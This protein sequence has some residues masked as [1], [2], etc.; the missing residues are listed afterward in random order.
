MFNIL[1][2]KDLNWDSS[3]MKDWPQSSKWPAQ[4]RTVPIGFGP[5]R[6][7]AVPKGQEVSTYSNPVTEDQYLKIVDEYGAQYAIAIEVIGD[8]IKKGSSMDNAIRE[9][10][11]RV[12]D[13]E[14]DKLRELA[15]KLK[16]RI[17]ME[18]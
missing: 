6:F 11:K 16:I 10:I 13:I 12:K 2:A 1:S 18:E 3:Y 15:N 5:T 4:M 8:E 9:A 17:E 7:F 14:E